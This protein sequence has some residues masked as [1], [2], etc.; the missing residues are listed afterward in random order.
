V[1]NKY[2]Q[3][4]TLNETDQYSEVNNFTRAFITN[5]TGGDGDGEWDKDRDKE[6]LTK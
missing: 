4:N 3:A 1:I 6:L 5:Q 2:S